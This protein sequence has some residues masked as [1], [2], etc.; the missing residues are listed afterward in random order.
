M[1]APETLVRPSE[2]LRAR[3][4]EVLE[5]IRRSGAKNPR[6]FGSVARGTDTPDSDIDILVA[7][8][9]ENVWTFVNLSEDLS[10]LLGVR[11]DVVSE[12]GLRPKHD[13]VLRDARPL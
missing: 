13:R 4:D 10:T 8:A 1:S 9:P 6:V 7:V 3:R 12:G 11:V 5:I 2:R